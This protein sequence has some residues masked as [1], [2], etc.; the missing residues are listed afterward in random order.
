MNGSFHDEQ[1]VRS[2]TAG[3]I[4]FRQLPTRNIW[5]W[6]RRG[7]FAIAL[8][9]LVALAFLTVAS[10]AQALPFPNQKIVEKARSYP[11]GSNGGWCKG[12][13]TGMVLDRVLEAYGF[14]TLQGYGAPG[15][16]Y[17]GDYLNH[18]GVLVDVNSAKPGDI[19]QA[20]PKGHKSDVN[21]DNMPT[22]GLHTAIVMRVHGPGN[23]WVR[24]SNWNWDKKISEHTWKPADWSGTSEIYVFR[25]GTVTT[26][27]PAEPL[28]P[29]VT[30]TTQSSVTV[31]WDDKSSNETGFRFQYRIGTGAWTAVSATAPANATSFT[32]T[33]LA[34]GTTYTFQVGAYNSAGTKWS[35]YVN[36]TTQTGI[37]LPAEPLNPRVTATTQSSVTVAWD[38]KS[39]N[40]TGFRFQYRIGTGAWTAVSATAPANATSFTI[41]G[42]AA[43]TTY[44][45]QVGAYNSAGTKWSAY[46]NG[47][48]QTGITLPA[49]PLNPRVTATT[50]SSVTVAWDDKSSNETGFR[51]QYRIGTGAW[52]A[53]S[54]TAP[55][56]ATSFTITG[57]AAGTTYTFQVGAYNSAGT[58]WSAYV[59]GTTQTGITL[60]AEP[61]NPRVT[62]TTQS[63]VTVAWDDKSSN[64]TGFRFQYRIG[65]GA[66]TAVSAT[67]PA[68]AT[69]FTITGLAAGTTYTFQVGAYNSAGTKWSAYVN[70]TTQTGV[71]PANLEKILRNTADGACYL[72]TVRGTRAW[73]PTG[74]DY[75][76]MVNN[77]VQVVQTNWATISRYPD[78]GYQAIV[79]RQ[80]DPAISGPWSWIISRSGNGA[81][82][83][84]DY[85]LTQ[86]AA[87]KSYVTNW[88][89]WTLSNGRGRVRVN[90]YIPTLDA[91]AGVVYQVFDGWTYLG[92]VLINQKVCYGFVQLGTWNFSSGTIV[93]KVFDNEGSGPYGYLMGFDCVEGIPV[94]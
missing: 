22:G 35:A 78:A 14:P 23:Y 85:Y 31:A 60:P 88:A 57:L 51:F 7:S 25:F 33:G 2:K 38:D 24:D 59:N 65:T 37:T 20:I 42:L 27:V 10:P 91:V 32:I 12:F 43:G 52:T 34:A 82:W 47:T 48:T 58:K 1:C 44:T 83:E 45:F 92:S 30:A 77:G 50:Q 40:E 49:E 11:E 76:A 70:G 94:G 80:D 46:V 3:R 93:V 39:S 8:L 17:Y 54:A 75:Q 66:W 72:I 36:G 87:G 89:T 55:A 62:A 53:V 28:N 9:L 6:A 5:P 13:A 68:N 79:R 15:G 41:T 26:S 86:S 74:G 69:S 29:R 18:G 19:I 56:N 21:D 64:E 84:N 16:L 4:S 81:G 61:L 67:A 71:D 73:I 90:A 63:S